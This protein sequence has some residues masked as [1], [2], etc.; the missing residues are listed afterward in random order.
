MRKVVV[1]Q[2][3]KGVLKSSLTS[4]WVG[5]FFPPCTLPPSVQVTAPGQSQLCRESPYCHIGEKPYCLIVKRDQIA[6]LPQVVA[7][8]WWEET[9]LAYRSRAPGCLVTNDGRR[10][11][12]PTC[13]LGCP[14]PARAASA[15]HGGPIPFLFLTFL[16]VIF[17]RSVPFLF[18]TFLNNIGNFSLVRS[19][20]WPA[21]EKTRG[22]LLNLSS[23]QLLSRLAA[24]TANVGWWEGD[25]LKHLSWPFMVEVEWV[26]SECLYWSLSKILLNKHFLTSG[27]DPLLCRP[28]H[29]PRPP[30]PPRPHQHPRSIDLCAPRLRRCPRCPG[31]SQT[32][33]PAFKS[34]QGFFH[35]C[36]LNM[37]NCWQL[38]KQ[39]GYCYQGISLSR[40]S[41]S[42]NH[43]GGILGHPH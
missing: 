38:F 2:R 6:S 18:L 7:F 24:G 37:T 8:S 26:L 15:C 19:N 16:L 5:C 27:F 12:L 4:S 34:L 33:G 20:N 1:W 17:H 10:H 31:C 39:G 11:S 25:N 22:K 40:G 30:R 9:Q 42:G 13:H 23:S 29:S 41:G 36:V 28:L 32:T 3:L 14:A 21:A 35:I 43:L